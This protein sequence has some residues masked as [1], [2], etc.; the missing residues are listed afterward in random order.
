MN[1]DSRYTVTRQS[2]RA[3]RE[4]L[5][6]K[7]PH[8]CRSTVFT[9]IAGDN[10]DIAL[11]EVQ[12]QVIL[13]HTSPVFDSSFGISRRVLTAFYNKIIIIIK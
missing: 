4:R 9:L 13:I 7:G 1:S 8:G 12:P 5:K 11:S 10:T 6:V 2:E 3:F